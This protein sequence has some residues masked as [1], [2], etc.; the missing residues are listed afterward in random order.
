MKLIFWLVKNK[1]NKKKKDAPIYCRVTIE[2]KRAEI[3]T[4]VRCK[5]TDWDSNKYRVKGNSE[6]A[7]DANKTL[8]KLSYKIYRTYNNQVF[9]YNSIPTAAEI[10][11]ILSIKERRITFLSELLIAYADEYYNMYSNENTKKLH[12]RFIE[13]ISKSL[14]SINELSISIHECDNYFLDRLANNFINNLEYS[15]TYTKKLFAFI[16]AALRYAFNRRYIDRNFAQEYKIPFKSDSEIIY[17]EEWEVKRIIQCEFDEV[18]QRSADMFIIQ[19]YTGLSY[20][21]LKNLNATHLTKDDNGSM[22]IN[23]RRQKVKTAECVIPVVK[24]VFD[25]LRKYDYDL[26]VLSNQKYNDALK[27]IATETKIPKRLTTHV[28]RKTFGTILL[29]KDVP[30]ETVSKLLGHSNTHVTQKHYAKV[31]HMKVARDIKVIL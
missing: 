19:C 16:K 11:K 4:G 14:K 9:N 31:L 5:E 24:I 7:Q 1:T 6:F 20:V 30:I 21:D 18:L 17:L 15:V 10:K 26:P 27:K 12:T 29:N 28:G 13:T 23:I 25:L 22:W 3:N 2:G 8:E